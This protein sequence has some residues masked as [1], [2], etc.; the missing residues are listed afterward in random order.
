MSLWAKYISERQ[1]HRIIES[2]HAFVSYNV[3]GD[4]IYL[5]DLY[6]AP[7]HRKRGVAQGL[8]SSLEKIGKE[9]G[10]KAL[11]TTTSTKTKGATYSLFVSI[12]YGLK[13]FKSDE[14]YVWL[15]KELV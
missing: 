7:E 12:K 13:V 9:H 2:D 4:K 8:M 3:Q 14:N 15:Y 11:I 6:V 10:C 1:G 5:E